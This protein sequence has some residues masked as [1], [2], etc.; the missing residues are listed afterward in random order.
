MRP[1]VVVDVGNSRIKWGLC[2]ADG[3]RLV[4][5]ASLP[6]DP[7]AWH[8]QLARW[9]FPD[10]SP[11]PPNVEHRTSNIERSTFGVRRSTF[12]VRGEG[13]QAL[14]SSPLPEGE[15]GEGGRGAGTWVLASVRPQRCERLRDWLLAQG[16]AVVLLERPEQL[17]LATRVI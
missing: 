14:S 17:P 6:E 2:S 12:D 8:E 3:Q 1:Q 16:H 15:R 9:G 11:P 5:T 10:P 13:E 7:L 4:A